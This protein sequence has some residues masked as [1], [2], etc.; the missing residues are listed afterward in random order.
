[1][2]RTRKTLNPPG[3]GSLFENLEGITPSS[4]EEVRSL[5]AGT[6]AWALQPEVVLQAISL[7]KKNAG[8][9]GMD[10][11]TVQE[12][13][14]HWALHG[15]RICQKLSAGTYVPQPVRRVAIPK[16]GGGERML[17]IPS[18]VDR[19]VQSMLLSSLEP[20]FEPVFSNS[21]FGFRPGRSQHDAVRQAKAYVS[22]GY[23]WVVDLDV[24][25]FFDR[26]NHD[27]LMSLV[28][29]R[30]TDR[31]MLKTIR[32]YLSAGILMEG[33][34]VRPHEG[35]PQGGPLS[36]L[37]ANI[38]LDELDKELE[39]RGHRFVR[40]ADDCNIYVRS[41][42]A[43]KR[44][45]ETTSRYLEVKLRLKVNRAKS[46]AA[47]VPERRFLGFCLRYTGQ[48][49]QVK[50]SDRSIE[51]FCERVREITSRVRRIPGRAMLQELDR[52]VR[53]W[54]GYYARYYGVKD[55]I[56]RLD[57]WINR[58]IRS[59]IWKQWKTPA[60]RRRNLLRG[61]VHPYHAKKAMYIGS[62]W[63]AS[64]NTAVAI[65]VSRKQI[66]QAGFTPLK[67]HWQRLAAW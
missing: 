26:V 8:A 51:R 3:Q 24:E 13:D 39:S 6:I 54:A 59:W 40:Y 2:R 44:V 58:R 4:H 46:A 12:L 15:Q 5:E 27:I 65:C 10:G 62:S 50:A 45:L 37:L 32:R 11:M 66:Q 64:G 30:V 49:W 28:R 31:A 56:M 67:E 22:E 38:L 1:M 47:Y 25:K 9:P 55:Q 14:A 42:G 20:L 41:E 7:V 35:T 34:L 52:F 60:C 61:G 23:E 48:I 18:V 29:K 33:I 19:V 21:S 43:A 36:P 63:K 17:G 57:P 53:G 16:P